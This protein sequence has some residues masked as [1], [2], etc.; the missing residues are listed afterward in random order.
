LPWHHGHADVLRLVGAADPKAELAK[1]LDRYL[2]KRT[3]Q[4]E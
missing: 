2:I 1:I 4:P 3:G